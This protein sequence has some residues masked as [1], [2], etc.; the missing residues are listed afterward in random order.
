MY[1]GHYRNERIARDITTIPFTSADVSSR[2]CDTEHLWTALS[3]D[4][5]QERRLSQ[6]HPGIN[7]NIFY[8][9]DH[10]RVDIYRVDHAKIIMR[11]N[12]YGPEH[13]RSSPARPRTCL[14]KCSLDGAAT[15]LSIWFSI[16]RFSTFAVSILLRAFSFFRAIAIFFFFYK[17]IH[18][19][20]YCIFYSNLH[21]FIQLCHV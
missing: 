21:N 5:C 4:H 14:G 13:P 8:R 6:D 17:H 12:L 16:S 19:G 10:P 11:I 9:L 3:H 15:H 20:K 1:T 2:S 18:P 7:T